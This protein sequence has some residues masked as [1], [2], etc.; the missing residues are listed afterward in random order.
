M[1][2]HMGIDLE[3]APQAV[4][5]YLT[6]PEKVM[7]WF[8][9]LVVFEYTNGGPGP[10][11]SFYWEEVV[12]G[13]TYSNHFRTTEWEPNRVFAYEMTES[14][15]FKSYTERWEI[16]PTSSGCRFSFDDN[17]VFPYGPLGRVMG[18]FGE[19]MARKSGAH[20]LQNLKTL[21]EAE[22]TKTYDRP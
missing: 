3:A 18:W 17:L 11:A 5:P 1:R 10:E 14:N 19:R 16:V 8:D 21:V 15:F 2:V 6:E 13:K 9:S 12:R 22:A 20:I 7:R 4:W